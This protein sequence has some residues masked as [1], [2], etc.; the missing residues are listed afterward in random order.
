MYRALRGAAL[1]LLA[2]PALSW[3]P[4]SHVEF[5]LRSGLPPHSAT[6]LGS[7]APDAVRSLCARVH[8]PAFAACL[9]AVSR[10]A[11]G[12]PA[13]NATQRSL[14]ARALGVHL[15][16]D[17][18]GH[19]LP[20]GLVSAADWHA[21]EFFV[22]SCVSRPLPPLAFSRADLDQTA[23]LL[24]SAGPLCGCGRALDVGRVREEL[25]S[26]IRLSRADSV[27]ATVLSPFC[28][29]GLS[30]IGAGSGRIGPSMACAV[31]AAQPWVRSE[32]VGNAPEL[33]R[34]IVQRQYADGDCGEP[35]STHPDPP[36]VL[37]V[38]SL[39]V[40]LLLWRRMRAGR[41]IRTAKSH[42]HEHGKKEHRKSKHHHAKRDLEAARAEIERLRAQLEGAGEASTH[43]RH[44]TDLHGISVIPAR[45]TPMHAVPRA[46]S[47]DVA[48][49]AVA[50]LATSHASV[51]G[52]HDQAVLA[53]HHCARA[54]GLE[55][56]G[57]RGEDAEALEAA[58]PASCLIGAEM[59]VAYY[60]YRPM[61]HALRFFGPLLYVAKHVA[62]G[63]AL[64]SMFAQVRDGAEV[65][66]HTEQDASAA[67]ADV[68]AL[69]AAFYET[70]VAPALASAAPATPTT[71]SPD[72]AEN[73][74]AVPLA[75]PP[76]NC[77]SPSSPVPFVSPVP[78]VMRGFC[79]S[80]T[81][82]PNSGGTGFLAN[83]VNQQD[84]EYNGR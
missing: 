25:S 59:Y 73:R 26:F 37:L 24:S 60:N 62:C 76:R 57:F 75:I 4:L 53:M 82:T 3:G 51:Q 1:L 70:L 48:R 17:L 15:A 16:T 40:V 43:R 65:F 32:D 79:E 35:R 83:I 30:A 66:V 12:S 14:F 27:V 22:D 52:A 55:F 36:A 5:A 46:V 11:T 6:L 77:L 7:I 34:S 54:A 41:R 67:V 44:S 19:R 47:V 8:T 13:W 18:S 45:S 21:A 10:N 69:V 2:C 20:G 64:V 31:A 50:T 68:F 28:H 39:L 58:M 49:R 74:L 84:G 29:A 42:K 33:A 63:G 61:S 80:W 81:G 23:E 71:R 56:A 72:V 78:A 9:A 38:A